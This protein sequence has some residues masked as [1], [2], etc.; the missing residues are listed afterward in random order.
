MTV[1]LVC[2]ATGERSPFPIRRCTLEPAPSR[3]EKA[4]NY[5]HISLMC[6]APKI[7]SLFCKRIITMSVREYRGQRVSLLA[8]GWIV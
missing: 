2:K 6:A 4:H 3:P 1:P 7:V 5:Y 8:R